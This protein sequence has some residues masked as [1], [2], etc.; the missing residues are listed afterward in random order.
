MFIDARGCTD[1]TVLTT[2]VCIIG[3]GPAGIAIARELAGHR[4]GVVLI[5]SGGLTAD[6]ATQRLYRGANV[7][8]IYFPLDACRNRYF[9]G[10][11][12]TWGGWCRPL[13][14]IDYRAR[15]WVPHSGW[16]FD[17][18]HLAPYCRRAEA[19]CQLVSPDY[20]GGVW[21]ARAGYGP[22]AVSGA[23][24][25]EVFQ[26][27]PPTLFGETYREALARAPN[28]TVLLHANALRIDVDPEGGAATGVAVGV[29]RGGSLRVT[30]RAF[31]LAAGGIENPRLLLASNA[32]RP[33]GLG[34]ERDL[35]GRFFMEHPHVPTGAF[36]PSARGYDNRFYEKRTVGASTIKGVLVPSPATAERE[37]ILG[38]SVS[39]EPPGYSVAEHFNAWPRRLV[40]ALTRMER[41][42]QRTRVYA[43]IRR[44]EQALHVMAGR[45]PRNAFARHLQETLEA[46]DGDGAPAD[47]APLAPGARFR[48][49]CRSEQ[50]PNPD[51]RVTIGRERDALGVPRAR[52][53]WRL[54]AL[55]L[56]TIRTTVTL[57]AAEVGAVG[58]GRVQLAE[59]WQDDA[60]AERIVG[61]PHHMGTTRMSNDPTRGVVDADSRVHSVANLY[62]AGSSVF[63]TSGYA[64]PTLT[65]LA[66]AIRLADHLRER[67]A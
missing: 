67:L 44:A 12:N 26:F 14:P 17:A 24:V 19:T 64:N 23:F 49:Y 57:L 27:S 8:R 33:A 35:V 39:P 45:G 43:A 55:D 29:L 60:W 1:G 52:L 47:G 21:A 42:S 34:N 65:L 30:A 53:D 9:G 46:A 31:V 41:L 18:A 58:A 3:G 63:P 48:L 5:E 25:H 59:G 4:L 22:L 36:L 56:H 66:L 28:V 40:L 62:V 16:P 38:I 6:R 32:V 2:D 54:S 11:T 10:S 7:G 51:S 13:D 20:D 37:G 61:G 50:A 15:S